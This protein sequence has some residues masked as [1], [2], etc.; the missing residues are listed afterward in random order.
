MS[1]KFSEG[2]CPRSKNSRSCI[3][4]H[5]SSNPMGGGKV[6]HIWSC[7][8]CGGKKIE[9][10]THNDVEC[11]LSSSL[12]HQWKTNRQ[13]SFQ[14]HYRYRQITESQS[15]FCCGAERV[16]EYQSLIGYQPKR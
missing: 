11:S 8:R 4:K 7:R 6:K 3:F 16:Y 9:S 5:S 2:A 14:Q 10:I 13:I 1:L 15:C 12:K